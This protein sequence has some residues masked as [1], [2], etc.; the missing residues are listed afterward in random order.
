[1]AALDKRP[2]GKDLL[3]RSFADQWAQLS[4]DTAVH[5]SDTLQFLVDTEGIDR[6]LL[7]SNFG[8]WDA[9]DEYRQMVEGLRL[10]PGGAEAILG[11]NA[12]RIFKI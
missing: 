10:P 7:G 11:G 4:F 5:R 2:F 9:E 6:V 1:M 8:G 12:Q 3:H